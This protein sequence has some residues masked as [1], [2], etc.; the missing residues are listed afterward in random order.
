MVSTIWMPET[1]VAASFPLSRIWT[2]VRFTRFLE[3]YWETS[4][5]RMMV[6]M[7]TRVRVT[8]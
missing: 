4:R 5:F 3:M 6:T 8:L 7:P 1:V 2:R